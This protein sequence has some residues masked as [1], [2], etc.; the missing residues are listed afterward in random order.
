MHWDYRIVKLD[1]DNKDLELCKGYHLMEV[2]VEDGGYAIIHT[3]P[4]VHGESL[5]GAQE[6][7][8][9]KE[10]AFKKHVIQLNKDLTLTETEE[11]LSM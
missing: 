11:I 9:L 1:V 3:E 2:V 7:F 5:K 4:T 8:K 6:D 10:L